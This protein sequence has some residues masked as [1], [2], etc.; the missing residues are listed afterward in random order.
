MA[1][2]AVRVL[3]AHELLSI[4]DLDHRAGSV[5]DLEDRAAI[6]VLNDVVDPL[7]ADSLT[8]Q[9]TGGFTGAL[10][11]EGDSP[12]PILEGDFLLVQGE[13]LL[14]VSGL[15]GGAGGVEG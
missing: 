7:S 2:S 4:P 11:V 13:G 5:T 10:Q 14:P 6:R 9:G 12:P 3:V 1:R 15:S 8:L